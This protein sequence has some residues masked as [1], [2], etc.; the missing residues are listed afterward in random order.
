MYA[1]AVLLALSASAGEYEF[2][3]PSFWLKYYNIPDSFCT[4]RAAVEVKA[5]KEVAPLFK[6]CGSQQPNSEKRWE[7]QC[8]LPPLEASDIV[9]RFR[10]AGRLLSYSQNCR[11]PQSFPE[12]DY[13]VE[14]LTREAANVG[15][16]SATHPG[17][18]GLLEAQLAHM[19]WLIQRRKR[20]GLASIS[21]IAAMTPAPQ[22]LQA[23]QIWR[24][25]HR[26]PAPPKR[27]PWSRTPRSACQQVDHIEVGFS[28]GPEE[29]KR[30][31]E[32]VDRI[33][34]DVPSP[35]CPEIPRGRPWRLMFSKSSRA[36]VLQRM[37]KIP[38]LVSWNRR[39]SP[40]PE[41]AL[42]DDIKHGILSREMAEAQAMLE[43]APHIRSLLLSEI[44]RLGV[45]A[46]G[47]NEFKG[48]T[49][50]FL[51]TDGK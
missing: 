29:V 10:N 3:N 37:V 30:F 39:P 18:S 6:A 23:I 16:S 1:L 31:T 22:G 32:L 19:D 40:L 4:M 33:G 25:A 49:L 45:N 42:P 26:N 48:G 44:E 5:F 20:A 38:K 36:D 14:S 12:L 8:S 46:R 21:L 24:A 15:L 7:A 13:K 28:V 27:L 47:L 2:N 9:G 51:R 17:I 43:R 35:T 50:I 41:E 34:S 11:E